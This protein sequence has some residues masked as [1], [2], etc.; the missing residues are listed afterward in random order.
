[1]GGRIGVKRRED[2]NHRLADGCK[3]GKVGHDM[4]MAVE[5]GGESGLTG[6]TE[7]G[8]RRA[9]ASLPYGLVNEP[10]R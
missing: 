1:M 10:K 8:E 6:G 4:E 5:M 2:Y 9:C 3:G 7:V